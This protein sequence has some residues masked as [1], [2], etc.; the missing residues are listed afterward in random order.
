MKDI[1]FVFKRDSNAPN[2]GFLLSEVPLLA[3]LFS[4]T[5]HICSSILGLAKIKLIFPTAAPTVLCFVP[6]AGRMLIRHQYFG[7]Y[8]QCWN[9]SA[10]T[11]QHYTY[12]HQHAGGGQDFRRGQGQDSW[13]KL[14]K[15]TFHTI[16]YLLSN[17]S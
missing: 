11:L 16:W 14:M 2:Y 7:Y 1:C 3:Y 8:Q 5:K 12:T 6:V 15:G 4:L 10:L 13:L 17:E 9:T